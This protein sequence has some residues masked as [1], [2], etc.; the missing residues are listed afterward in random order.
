MKRSHMACV[1]EGSP[2][3]HVHGYPQVEQAIPSIMPLIPGRTQHQK[4]Y[5]HDLPV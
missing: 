4:R 3:T 2:A 1:T 5:V